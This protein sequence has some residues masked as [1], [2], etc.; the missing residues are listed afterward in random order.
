MVIKLIC[1]AASIFL[2]LLGIIQL[3]RLPHKKYSLSSNYWRIVIFS[4]LGCFYD[5]IMFVVICRIIPE[6]EY[7]TGIEILAIIAVL[8]FYAPACVITSSLLK[9]RMKQF[10]DEKHNVGR[11]SALNCSIIFKV[12]FIFIATIW[13]VE[14]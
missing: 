13:M 3:N 10:Q 7:G 14:V 9:R 8:L 11:M 6:G 2:G 4:S 1:L 5:I 12:M